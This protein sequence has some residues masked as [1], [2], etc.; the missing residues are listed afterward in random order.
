M[1]IDGSVTLPFQYDNLKKVNYN[2]VFSVQGEK[3]GLVQI[4]SGIPTEIVTCDYDNVIQNDSDYSIVV[5]R[6]GKFGI[7][8]RYGDQ[9]TEIKYSML[10]QIKYDNG[11]I[12]KG[13]LG[14]D[15]YLI[16]QQGQY[17]SDKPF[18]EI[19]II[20]DYDNS[21][22][23]SVKFSY[24]KVK[25]GN[26]YS[27]IDKIGKSISEE[28]FDDIAFESKNFLVVK[29]KNKYA[30]FN[31]L[32]SQMMTGYDYDQIAFEEKKMFGFKKNEVEQIVIKGQTIEKKVIKL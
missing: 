26:K 21:S 14:E 13:A 11:Y 25:S 9:I 5:E 15:L 23:Y 16:D 6:D 31:L 7:L 17:I 18:N 4:N 10:E 3:C 29:S 12:Y 2:S 1:R 28:K 22:S 24:F 20:P 19:D 30:I 8:D 32:D 27:V